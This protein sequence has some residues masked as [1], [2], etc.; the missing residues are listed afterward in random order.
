MIQFAF[1]VTVGW[2]HLVSNGRILFGRV[3]IVPLPF[4]SK[5]GENTNL[6]KRL[7]EKNSCVFFRNT[8]NID[9]FAL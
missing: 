8:M 2:R 5:T 7:F 6:D 4:P 1:Q 3:L 9:I